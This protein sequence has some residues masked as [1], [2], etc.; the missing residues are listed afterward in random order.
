MKVHRAPRTRRL[1]NPGGELV[2]TELV[3]FWAELSGDWQAVSGVG[4]APVEGEA[5]ISALSASGELGQEKTVSAF[6]DLID[7]DGQLF[8]FSAWVHTADEAPGDTARIVVEYRDETNTVVLD[9]F[10]SG[11]LESP[12]GWAQV[13]AVREAPIGTRVIRVRLLAERYGDGETHAYFDAISLTSL[14]RA[15]V[16]VADAAAFEDDSGSAEAT[17][18]VHLSCPIPET[19]SYAFATADGTATAGADYLATSGIV[20][21]PAETTS[22]PVPV[23]VLGDSEVEPPEVFYLELLPDEPAGTVLFDPRGDGIISDRSCPRSPGY[24]KNHLEAWPV[25]ELQIGALVYGVEGL[26]DILGYG[27]PDPSYHL[28]RQLVATELNL[29]S[30]TDPFIDPVALDGHDFLVVYPPGSKPKG[31]A[32]DEA[33]A[34]K[35]LLDEYNNLHCED[36]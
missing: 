15:V 16:T 12:F 4:P 29:H 28:A 3:P 23:T 32:K 26:T 27:G 33:E 1:T 25:A 8:G 30:G 20:T 7:G 17:F 36:D 13:T 22:A 5:I 10:D 34:I 6:A 14:R 19:V 24:W 31:A 21:L 11:E 18:Q 35:D 9:A 2:S